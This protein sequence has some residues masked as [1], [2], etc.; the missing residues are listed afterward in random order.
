MQDIHYIMYSGKTIYT[1]K[2]TIV[3][4]LYNLHTFIFSEEDSKEKL[5]KQCIKKQI[6]FILVKE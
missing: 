3:T 2:R 1:Y 4:K 5:S 6:K